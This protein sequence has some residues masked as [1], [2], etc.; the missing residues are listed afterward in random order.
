MSVPVELAFLTA[1]V[2]LNKTKLTI[3]KLSVK[4]TAISS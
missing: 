3:A 1:R 4:N 2:D